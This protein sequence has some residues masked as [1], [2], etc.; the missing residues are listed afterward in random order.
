MPDIFNEIDK[1][2]P[3]NGFCIVGITNE[4]LFIDENNNFVFGLADPRSRKAAFSF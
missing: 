4:D 2:L 1:L 3:S